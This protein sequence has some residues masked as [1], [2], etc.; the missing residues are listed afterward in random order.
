M[1]ALRQTETWEELGLKEPELTVEEKAEG[2]GIPL[3]DYLKIC[4]FGEK[5]KS[6]EETKS[7][8]KDK[9]DEDDEDD[10]NVSSEIEETPQ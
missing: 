4:E 3:E 8:E 1:T 2:T 6:K 10:A 7:I 9:E 5:L